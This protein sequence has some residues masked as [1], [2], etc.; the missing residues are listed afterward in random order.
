MFARNC[1]ITVFKYALPLSI[2]LPGFTAVSS[3]QSVWQKMKQ[4]VLQQQCQQGLQKACQALEQMK[5][6]QPQQSQQPQ[7]GPERQGDESGRSGQPP[8]DRGGQHQGGQERDESGPIHPPQGTK[9]VETLLAP[10]APQARFFIS[11]HGVHLATLENSGSR[12]V[13]YYDGVPGPKFDDILGGDSNMPTM[14]QVAFSPDGNRYAY[15]GRAG[16]QMVVMVDGKEL[17][18]SSE[19]LEGQFNGSSCGLGF[20]SNSQHVFMTQNVRTS[21]MKGGSFTRFFFDGKPAALNTGSLT[22]SD[23]NVGGVHLSMS[24]DGNHY[25]Y[26]ATDPNDEQKWALVID[27]KVAPYRGGN[28][29]WTADSQHLYTTLV[30]SIPGKGQVAE[31]MLDGKPLIRADRI[32]LH[33]APAGNM[34]VAEVNAASNTP[35]PL[36]FLV[37]D[38]K[39]VPGS[40]IVPQGGVDIDQVTISPNGKHFA[41]RF[42][43]AQ[44][45]QYVSVDGKAGQE[46]QSVDHLVFTSDSSKVTY[47]AFSNAKPY[48]I[49]GDQESEACHGEFTIASEGSHAGTICGLTGGAPAIYL[50]GRTLPLANGALGASDLRF[51]PDGQHYV[52]GAQFQGGAQRLVIDGIVQMGSNLGTP[53]LP[54]AHYVFSPDS[55]HIAADSAPPSPSSEFAS[56]I[57]VDGKYIPVVANSG[58]KRL[59]FTADSKHIVWAQGVA[60]R[61]ALRIFVDGKA[62]AEGDTAIS[63][64]SKEGWWD[65]APDGSLSVL[66]QDE[67]NLKRITITPS[68]ETSLATLGGGGAMVAKR[69]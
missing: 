46:Y 64:N 62:V 40:E 8:S 51:S 47:T 41:A 32:R 68:A 5:Q 9:V 23:G 20:T 28:P 63:P 61:D 39:K 58:M 45:H 43:N 11:P 30:T 31:A 26:V 56:G 49:I 54:R 69:D 2:L 52:Y 67:K 14:V 19:S 24:P 22:Q 38:G 53:S 44:G 1:L 17:M 16:S 59:E 12:A 4:N 36:R 33:V 13:V 18:R 60:S 25:A 29:Q 10:V 6:K 66:V 34:V 37:V 3:A 27:G 7:Q 55:R 21:M 65:M 50:D 15:C 48:A 57:F 42:T 35:R